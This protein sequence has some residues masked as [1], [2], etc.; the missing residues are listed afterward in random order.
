MAES[1]SQYLKMD[2]KMMRKLLPCAV[3]LSAKKRKGTPSRI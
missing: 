3:K 2:A 1:Y